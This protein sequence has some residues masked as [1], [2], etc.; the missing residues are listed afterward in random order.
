MN[1]H[2]S[3][4]S[5]TTNRERE[6]SEY[7]YLNGNKTTCDSWSFELSRWFWQFNRQT[8]SEYLN[9]K[10]SQTQNKINHPYCGCLLISLL[11]DLSIAV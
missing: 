3:L 2:E 7:N 5:E 4:K 11:F 1:I 8:S 9:F 10:I 6:S